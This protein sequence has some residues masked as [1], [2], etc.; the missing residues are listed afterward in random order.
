MTGK[1]A[2]TRLL[3]AVAGLAATAST[4]LAAGADIKGVPNSEDLAPSADGRWVFAGSMP[5]GPVTAGSLSVI[6][7]R[8]G[9][10]RRLYPDASA[11]GKPMLEGCPAETP[12]FAPHGLALSPAGDRL[13]AVNHGGRESI[14]LFQ[15]VAGPSPSLRWI[16]CVVGPAGLDLNSVAA[17]RDGTLFVTAIKLPS[18][19]KDF[20]T[21]AGKV[22]SWRAATGW[23]E[24]AGGDVVTPNGILATPDGATLYVDSYAPGELVEL[25]LGPSGAT[26]RTVKLGFM[27]D[28]VRW[29]RG[30]T[31]TVAG[32]RAPFMDIA[33]CY[34][35]KAAVCD[36]PS[37]MAQIDL[38]SF[39]VLCQ[40]PV[41]LS[42][43]TTAVPVGNEIWLSSLRGDAIRRLRGDAFA[44]PNC[45]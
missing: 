45:E 10:V 14:E 40:H 23:R 35:S 2:L 16:G 21:T 8:S 6:D 29:G 26:R 3:S 22:L 43:A 1:S 18:D 30:G 19:I 33:R 37:A 17:T 28:N 5:G 20:P 34:Q 13:Y 24:V 36:I 7:V 38:A 27:A 39:S 44:K 42:F 15:V 11:A 41:D 32:Q 31:L 4:A 12:T 9:R 25:T